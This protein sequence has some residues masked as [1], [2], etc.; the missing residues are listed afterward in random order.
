MFLTRLAVT[1]VAVALLALIGSAGPASAVTPR[2]TDYR[3]TVQSVEP[4]APISVRVI[5]GDTLLDLT[6]DPGHE[7]VV[8]G[9]G[10]EPY[11]RIEAD[12]TAQVNQRSP[13]VSLNRTR[14]A[15]ITGSD[16]ASVGDQPDWRTLGH[17][18]RL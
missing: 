7:V 13:A 14:D 9:Y 4:S 12:G 11:L 5:G 15:T 3:S 2:P 17:D 16:G 1:V 6:A 10:G 18:G 8:Q